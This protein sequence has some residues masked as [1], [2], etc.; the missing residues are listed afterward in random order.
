MRRYMRRGAII[1]ALLVPLLAAATRG[2]EVITAD[3]LLGQVRIVASPAMA[4]RGVGT[5]GIE[6][7]AEHI[8]REFQQ[9]GLKPGGT[10]GYGQT[11]EVITGVRVGPETRRLVIRRDLT[12]RNRR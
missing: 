3:A 8:S 2:E 4:G 6:K 5:P 11:F 10:Q 7:A 9:A 1:L 12:R